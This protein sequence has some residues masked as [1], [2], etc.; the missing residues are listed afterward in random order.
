MANGGART[1]VHQTIRPQLNLVPLTVYGHSSTARKIDTEI[2]TPERRVWLAGLKF[3]ITDVMIL[4]RCASASLCWNMPS[5]CLGSWSFHLLNTL[6]IAAV[7]FAVRVG[8]VEGVPKRQG[9]INETGAAVSISREPA[10]PIISSCTDSPDWT[11]PHLEVN[12]CHE[13]LARLEAT[14]MDTGPHIYEFFDPDLGEPHLPYQQVPLPI[15]WSSGTC[16][17]GVSMIG[18]FAPG[19]LPGL[20]LVQGHWPASDYTTFWVIHHEAI[21]I[22][23]RCVEHGE[24]TGWGNAGGG[25]GALAI[26]VFATG[27]RIWDFWGIHELAATNSTLVH[28]THVTIGDSQSD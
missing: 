1:E 9:I 21:N 4:I 26:A 16:T 17:I 20:P 12:D 2:T 14:S 11:E 13:A 15:S 7:A 23:S 10:H 3:G 22:F 27:A 19:T 6:A 18:S 25:R 8:M 24:G 5:S 28:M